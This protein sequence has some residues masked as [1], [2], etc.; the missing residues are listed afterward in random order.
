MQMPSLRLPTA[1]R[2]LSS[3]DL[4]GRTVVVGQGRAFASRSNGEAA[5]QGRGRTD[6]GTSECTA[7]RNKGLYERAWSRSRVGRGAALE[8]TRLLSLRG[9]RFCSA[10]FR[11]QRG[12]RGA[13]T[14]GNPG[15]SVSNID[16]RLGSPPGQA[17]PGQAP[18]RA[19]DYGA[20]RGAAE[21]ERHAAARGLDTPY[22]TP[23][24]RQCSFIFQ[25][26]ALPSW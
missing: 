20:A 3:E 14:T 16:K 26:H 5:R 19:E 1:R 2:L 10:M 17:R 22:L 8:S 24:E 18:Q 4:F 23:R 21:P 25:W 13:Q 15:E 12:K 7:T 11:R 9:A 6:S